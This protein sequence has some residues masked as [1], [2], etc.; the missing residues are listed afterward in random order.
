DGE[1]EA[2]AGRLRAHRRRPGHL[3]RRGRQGATGRAGAQ[4]DAMGGAVEARQAVNL[5]AS[6]SGVRSHAT[7]RVA[8][9]RRLDTRRSTLADIAGCRRLSK[10]TALA[11]ALVGSGLH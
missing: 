4:R 1:R 7:S 6:E 10:R 11:W 2:G 3:L 9:I 8:A 5:L